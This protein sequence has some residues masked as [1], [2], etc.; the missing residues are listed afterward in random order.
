VFH[1]HVGNKVEREDGRG[2]EH[3]LRRWSIDDND[4]RDYLKQDIINADSQLVSIKE[5]GVDVEYGHLSERKSPVKLFNAGLRL[6]KICKEKN[7]D[8]VHVFW[9]S[10]T[11]ITAVIFSPCP[12]IIS[13]SGSD[14]IGMVSENGKITLS[15]HISKFL[16]NSSALLAASIITKS[17][18][19][20]NELWK[21][22]K[23]KSTAIP[24][25]LDLSKFKPMSQM[26]AQ[27]YLGWS[28]EKK[29]II[30]FSGLGATVKDLPLAQKIFSIIQKIIPDAEMKIL[31]KIPH[32]ELV[33]YY[34]AADVML[35][36][37][38][39]EGSNNSLKE[40]RACNLPIVSVNCG[41]A[42]ERLKNVS[43]SYVIDSRDPEE[44]ASN[45]LS[46]LKSDKR[47]NGALLSE[48]VKMET[49]AK[50]IVSVYNQLKNDKQ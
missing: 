40:A 50:K 5:L 26:E 15:G 32:N 39:H 23:N 18:N 10:T 45:V 48:D 49:I 24:N 2:D 34:N 29:Y 17:E 22:S 8:F 46:V 43:N 42:A 25:G 13:F 11:A 7:I 41:D 44:I 37:S 6:R 28:N 47:S 27:N 9:G 31:N 14:L 1:L 38:F 35:L 12:V 3:Y 19:M 16:S 33:Y 30:F 21:I 4:Y 36:T 20:R